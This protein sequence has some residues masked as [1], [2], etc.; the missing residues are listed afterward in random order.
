MSKHQDILDYLE[1]LA[2]GKKVSVRSIS[3][4]LKV[5]DGTAYRAIKEAENRGIVETKPRSG[6]VRIEKKDG[7]VLTV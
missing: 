1:K 3:N 2:I 6:T 7:F 4:H 5:S